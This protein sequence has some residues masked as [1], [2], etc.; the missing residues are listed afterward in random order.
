[1]EIRIHHLSESFLQSFLQVS[2]AAPR[3]SPREI[4]GQTLEVVLSHVALSISHAAACPLFSHSSQTCFSLSMI[5]M[6]SF[7]LHVEHGAL[8]S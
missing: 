2:T 1:M 5:S 3:I 4:F 6:D 8:D 7:F